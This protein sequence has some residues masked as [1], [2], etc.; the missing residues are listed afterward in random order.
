MRSTAESFLAGTAVI[1]RKA[2][3]SD[4]GGGGTASWI[5]RGTVSARLAPAPSVRNAEPVTGSRITPDANWMVTLPAET[6]V[7]REDRILID[8]KT[9]EVAQVPDRTYEITMPV[10][11]SEVI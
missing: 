1:K 10:L 2:I 7:L 11:A 3:A 4:S 8:G 6:T 5:A 9:L